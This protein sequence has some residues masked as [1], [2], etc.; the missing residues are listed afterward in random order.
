MLKKIVDNITKQRELERRAQLKRRL[1]KREARIGGQ[2]FGPVPKGHRREF[3][4]LDQHSWVWHEEWIDEQGTKHNLTTRYD[5]RPDGIFKVQNGQYRPVS[6]DET[7]R[8]VEAGRLYEQRV[9][10]ELYGGVA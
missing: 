10:N 5:I 1:I 3:F 7:K 8:L 9:M 6:K 2:L 4:C